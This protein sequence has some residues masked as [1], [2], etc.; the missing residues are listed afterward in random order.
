MNSFFKVLNS[1]PLFI[2]DSGVNLSAKQNRYSEADWRTSRE[3]QNLYRG[4]FTPLDSYL[5][6]LS[7]NSKKIQQA[8]FYSAMIRKMG[9]QSIGEIGGLPFFHSYI[10]SRL[11]PDVRFILTDF[12]QFNLKRFKNI[13]GDHNVEFTCFDAKNP[14]TEVFERCDLLIM[15]G[16]DYALTDREIIDLIKSIKRP[17]IIG[18]STLAHTYFSPIYFNTRT[19]DLFKTPFR[20]LKRK[21]LQQ[22]GSH[23]ILRSTAYFSRLLEAYEIDNS[24]EITTSGVYLK[25]N[26]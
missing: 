24:I 15:Q 8:I 22:S 17:L 4:K 14:N 9:V 26:F 19:Y 13:F 16:V 21:L 12:D 2:R 5:D 20:K 23:G 3:E 1:A 10:I 25:V 6:E 11:L 18:T 7:R